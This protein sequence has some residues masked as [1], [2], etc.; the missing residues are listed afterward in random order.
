MK[1]ERLTALITLGSKPAL[2]KLLFFLNALVVGPC[3]VW[4][5]LLM[6]ISSAFSSHKW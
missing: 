1:D 5:P 4:I 2:T 3:T 6:I